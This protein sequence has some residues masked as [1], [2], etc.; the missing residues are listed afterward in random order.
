MDCLELMLSITVFIE[1][2]KIGFEE[3]AAAEF[4][5]TFLN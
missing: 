3:V 1:S 2:S 4:L 5:G